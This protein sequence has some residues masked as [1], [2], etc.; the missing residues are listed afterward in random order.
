MFVSKAERSKRVA[1]REKCSV[2]LEASARIRVTSPSSKL[3]AQ[4]A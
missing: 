3:V 1:C 2:L 4:L